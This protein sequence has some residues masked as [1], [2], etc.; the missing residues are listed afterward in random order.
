MSEDTSSQ[1]W[2]RARVLINSDALLNN[3]KRVRDYS[4]NAQVMAVIKANA[5]GHGMLHAAT[6]LDSADMFAVAMPQEAFALRASGC[7][8]PLL[9]LHGFNHVDELEKFSALNIS[10][11]IHQSKQLDMLIDSNLTLP[12]DAWLKVDTGMHRL[13]ISENDAEHYFA[14]LRNSSNVAKIYIM[15]HF[16]NADERNNELNNKQLDRFIKVTNDIDVE[17]SMANSAAII[18]MPKSHFEMVRPGIMLYGSSPFAGV[19]AEELG[20]QAAMQFEAEL[21][22]I[23]QLKAGDAVGYGST[24]VADRDMTMGIVAAGYGDG[25]PRHA[26]NGTPVWIN[27]HRC[28]LIGRVSMDSISIDLTGVKASVGDRVVLW[29]R[30][31][32]IDEIAA[33]SESIAYELM[34]N[35]GAAY[36]SIR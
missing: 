13:G 3:L 12:V 27:G 10:A 31:L 17:C 5:Y 7:T 36:F 4:P 26:K 32:G 2:R 8:K 14:L 16:A 33:A 21:L 11:V 22:A 18:S 23:K 28:Q 20:L 24:F 30:E 6:V 35:A 9:V 19:T 29:G 25:Y 34:C 1:H 15:S